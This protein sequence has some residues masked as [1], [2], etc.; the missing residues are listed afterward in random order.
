M[1]EKVNPRTVTRIEVDRESIFKHLILVFGAA[2]RGFEYMRKVIGIDGTFLKGPYKGVLLVAT[3][4][5]GNNKC[6]PIAWG[7]VDSEN[8]DAWT[9]FLIRLREVIGDTDELVFISDRAQ[10][11]KTAVSTVY[12]KV[13]H[14]ACAWHVAQ[15]V[16]SKFRCG[17]IMGAY[18]KAMDAYR[19]EQF[20][21]YMLVISQR[22]PRVAEY[23]EHQVGFNTW[24]RCHFPGMRK[25]SKWWNKR[26][27]VGMT[28]TSLLTLNLE[29]ELRP[30]F[31]ESNSLLTIQLNSVMFHVKGGGILEAVGNIHNLTC[32]CHIF[33][34]DRLPCVHAIAAASHAH[35]SVYTF[36]S[37]YYTK[38][39]Y[40]LAYAETIYLVGSQSQ[41]DV[42]E[43]VAARVFLPRIVKERKRGRPR[44]SRYPSAGEARKHK[45]RCLKC[46]QLEHYQ[47]SC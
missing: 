23:L 20:Q 17:D 7:I 30:R 42:L 46:G 41:W 26:C 16:R 43:E 18:W 4:Q 37:R 31:M 38:Y 3:A 10:S 36:T 25:I 8:E 9:W 22:D 44:M 40:M 21:G 12:E 29:D 14:S 27:V 28:L 1:L 2:I 24:S 39:F 32:T 11:I 6:Y 47:K 5:D 45:N 33:D 15:N 35:V 19:V 34:I 13:Q